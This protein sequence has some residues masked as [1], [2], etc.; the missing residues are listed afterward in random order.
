MEVCCTPEFEEQLEKLSKNK[1]YAS[2]GAE[3][4][5][6]Y[7]GV[8]FEQASTGDLLFPMPG[9]SFI[10]KRL[11]GRGGYRVYVLAVVR[12]ER[13]YLGFVHPKTGRYGADNVTTVRK[14]AI[15]KEIQ[16]AIATGQ[17]YRLEPA[18]LQSGSL[19]YIRV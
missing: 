2:L 4:A 12:E 5:A 14:A 15:L 17:L 13:V 18:P 16:A 6:A 11:A 3:L 19:R 7:C 9:L 10:K 8:T 1:S